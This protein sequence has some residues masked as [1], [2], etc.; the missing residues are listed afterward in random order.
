MLNLP[1]GPLASLPGAP[2][3]AFQPEPA[4]KPPGHVIP[5]PAAPRSISVHTDWHVVLQQ[6]C[7]SDDWHC[8]WLWPIGVERE[9]RL[10]AWS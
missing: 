6:P 9:T 10:S 1:A 2:L 7:T 4:W 3:A 8:Q 5:A